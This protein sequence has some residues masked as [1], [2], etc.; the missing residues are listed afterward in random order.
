MRKVAVD[1]NYFIYASNK[2]SKF[3]FE[4]VS[5]L[6]DKNIEICITGKSLR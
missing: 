1:T 4:A 2:E 6:Q 5:F 3:Y